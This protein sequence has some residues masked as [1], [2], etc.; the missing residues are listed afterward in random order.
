MPKFEGALM[1]TPLGNTSS[2][3][4]LAGWITFNCIHTT[5]IEWN[6][7][8]L[9]YSYTLPDREVHSLTFIAIAAYGSA[10]SNGIANTTMIGFVEWYL[11]NRALIEC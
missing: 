3:Y 7:V 1:I 9:L 5:T 2:S 4:N 10:G 6:M 8:V 11:F